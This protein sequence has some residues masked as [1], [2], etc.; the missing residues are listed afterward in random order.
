MVATR[1]K[2]V[3]VAALKWQWAGHITRRTEGHWGRKVLEQ[4]PRTGRRSVGGPMV[5]HRPIEVRKYAPCTGSEGPVVV[6]RFGKA[7]CSALDIYGLKNRRTY[8]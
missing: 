7:L 2:G 1:P 3:A 8:I 4:G 5:D 6:A